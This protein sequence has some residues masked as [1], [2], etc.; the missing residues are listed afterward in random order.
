MKPAKRKSRRSLAARLALY[1]FAAALLQFAAVEAMLIAGGQSRDSR[2]T[3]YVLILGASIDGKTVLPTLEER[4]KAGVQYLEKY[5]GSAAIVSGG[6][7]R[8]EDI[9]EAEAMESYLIARGIDG[10]RII[11]EDM[12]T[13]TMENFLYTRRLLKEL[14]GRDIREITVI[15]NDFHVL[16]TRM[17]AQR[18]GFAPYIISC[19]TPASVLKYNYFREYF[20]LVKSFFADK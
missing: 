9:T 4:L 19:K 2:D 8:G 7:G 12:A 18:N 3:G 1:L 13:S 15:T 5:P 17:L 6:Q 11:R 14:T 20:A 10:K 16:R